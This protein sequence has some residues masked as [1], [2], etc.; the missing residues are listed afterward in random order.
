MPS[1]SRINATI[2]RAT[3]AREEIDGETITIDGVDYT[4]TASAIEE[5]YAVEEAGQSTRQQL[6][7]TMRIDQFLTDPTAF[8]PATGGMA[9]DG[10][11]PDPSVANKV[12]RTLWDGGGSDLIDLSAYATDL[13]VQQLA[14]YFAARY[15]I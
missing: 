2:N 12:F 9:V 3:K 11:A 1:K 7:V 5:P 10:Q 4:C 13:E 15:G 14:R 8:D 6:S